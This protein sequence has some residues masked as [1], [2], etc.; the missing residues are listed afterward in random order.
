MENFLTC[1]S[2]IFILIKDN[3]SEKFSSTFFKRWRILKAEP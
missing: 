1:G 2:E 3:S